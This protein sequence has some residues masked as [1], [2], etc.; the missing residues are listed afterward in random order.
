MPVTFKELGHKGRI[1]NILFQLATTMSVAFSNNDNP[2]FP[3]WEGSKYFNIP[4]E[5]FIDNINSIKTINEWKEPSFSYEKILYKP[6][7]NLSGYFQSEKYFRESKDKILKYLSPRYSMPQ[8]SMVTSIHVRRGD[9]TKN[10]LDGCFEILQKDYYDKAIE[11]LNEQT[12]K[13]FVFSDDISAAKAMFNG[14]KFIF[15]ENNP[16]YL[17]FALQSACNNHIIANSSFSW[18]A[19]YLNKNIHKKVIA[20]SKWFGPKLLKTHNTKDLIPSGWDII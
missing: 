13:F 5:F 17:D 12:E 10:H 19:A 14:A 2:I 6:N 18:W 4:K 20:P 9:Y 3:N 15:I 16:D 8:L 1:G 11:I 7:M